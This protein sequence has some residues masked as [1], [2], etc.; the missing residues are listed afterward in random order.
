MVGTTTTNERLENEIADPEVRAVV[1]GYA[2]SQAKNEFEIPT[3]INKILDQYG[4]RLAQ[5]S[6]EN[7]RKQAWAVLGMETVVTKSARQREKEEM[8]ENG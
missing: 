1:S 4:N 5:I 7:T 3:V 2:Y 6:G 8:E